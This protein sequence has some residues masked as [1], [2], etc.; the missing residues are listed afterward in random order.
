MPKLEIPKLPSEVKMILPAIKEILAE[1][2]IV[3]FFSYPEAEFMTYTDAG[4]ADHVNVPVD[5]FN[6]G[7]I[8]LVTDWGFKLRLRHKEG[9]LCVRHIVKNAYQDMSYQKYLFDIFFET[10]KDKKEAYLKREAE[11]AKL[12]AYHVEKKRQEAEE[13]EKAE[14]ERRKPGRPKRAEDFVSG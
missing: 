3:G 9:T 5:R 7:C 10:Y 1:H 8:V 13:S 12:E 6:R 11:C 4:G 14:I 2:E